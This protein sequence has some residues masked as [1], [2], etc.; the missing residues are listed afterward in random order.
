M[1]NKTQLLGVSGEY[2]IA[3]LLTRKGIQAALLQHGARDIDIL[4]SSDDGSRNVSIQ[5]KTAAHPRHN[6]WYN[7]GAGRLWQIG[8]IPQSSKNKWYALLD[9]TDAEP[10]CVFVPS[11]WIA[12]F[13]RES[14][15]RSIFYLLDESFELMKRKDSLI[16]FLRDGKDVEEGLW[17][18]PER[19]ERRNADYAC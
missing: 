19:N 17:H 9:F 16:H 12:E 6:K 11:G 7:M 15:S 1:S 4:A 13:S 18:L 5:V 3:H 14:D 8:C 10:E 2:Y